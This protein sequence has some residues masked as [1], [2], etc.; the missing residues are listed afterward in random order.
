MIVDFRLKVKNLL[1]LVFMIF[2]FG[3][4]ILVL[5]GQLIWLLYK[6]IVK[7]NI[8]VTETL[9]YWV[10]IVLP[11]MINSIGYVIIYDYDN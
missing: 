11:I 8:L 10:W 9:I 5:Y 1:I 6:N 7:S 2:F 3:C 4:Y